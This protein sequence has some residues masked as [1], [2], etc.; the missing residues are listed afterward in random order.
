MGARIE[1]RKTEESAVSSTAA[2][3]LAKPASRWKWVIVAS[4]VVTAIAL[5]SGM[6]TAMSHGTRGDLPRETEQT[7]TIGLQVSEAQPKS[8]EAFELSYSAMDL[9]QDTEG[10]PKDP[11]NVREFVKGTWYVQEQQETADHKKDA[12]YCGLR[13]VVLEEGSPVGVSK[14][15]GD[16]RE[17]SLYAAYWYANQGGVN[18]PVH[19]GSSN[20]NGAIG[21]DGNKPLCVRQM[22]KGYVEDDQTGKK[23]LIAPCFTPNSLAKPMWVLDVGYSPESRRSIDA[24]DGDGG[25]VR[26]F[27]RREKDKDGWVLVF[28]Q[29]VDGPKENWRR[30]A[31]QWS[32][33]PNDPTASQYSI[34]DELE[35]YRE[36]GKLTFKM[37][38]PNLGGDEKK[39]TNVWS[40]TSNPVLPATKK[41][42]VEGYKKIAV[43]F[44]SKGWYGLER[45]SDYSLL[46]GAR[47]NGWWYSVGARGAQGGKIPGPAGRRGGVTVDVVELY[48]KSSRPAAPAPG[49]SPPPAKSNRGFQH[50]RDKGYEWAIVVG[51]QPT[52]T[53]VNGECIV[54]GKTAYDGLWLMTRTPKMTPATW[55]TMHQAL[56]AKNIDDTG[57]WRVE[58]EGCEYAGANICNTWID[59]EEYNYPECT[60]RCVRWCSQRTGK[61]SSGGRSS[62]TECCDRQCAPASPPPAS[63]DSAFSP[64]APPP[65]TKCL[66]PGGVNCKPEAHG[67]I[68]IG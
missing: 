1:L 7:R 67:D 36:D 30:E 52:E 50:I 13:T 9:Q 12:F 33:N 49:P 48:V 27:G 44:S 65:P 10:T 56:V 46:D 39:T 31:D 29:T 59:G 54:K 41:C 22:E 42:T 34:L 3:E 64:A 21:W 66:H 63:L 57:L 53:N 16:T 47:G 11:F 24:D 15:I 58:H 4:L 45:C 25:G 23:M 40:Q 60:C 38:W 62:T 18:G 2:V 32:L 14:L 26:R 37:K 8:C 17:S 6:A 61:E 55:Q 43:A 51:G 20:T 28:R 5:A 68:P 19:Q 35:A